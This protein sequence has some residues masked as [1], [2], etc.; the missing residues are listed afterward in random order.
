MDIIKRALID[1]RAI[2]RTGYPYYR[3]YTCS[4]WSRWGRWVLAGILILF[5]LIFILAFLCLAR[6]RRRR[7]ATNYTTNPTPMVANTAT[8]PAYGYNNG[9]QQEYGQMNGAYG[10]NPPYQ[11]GYNPPPGPPPNTYG[12]YKAPN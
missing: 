6:R 9:P 2:C 10:A 3:T 4:S 7:R 1:K 5:A 8:A 12:G 11:Q